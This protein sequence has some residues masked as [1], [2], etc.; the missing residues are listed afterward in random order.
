MVGFQQQRRL[1]EEQHSG[2][3]GAQ[4]GTTANGVGSTATAAAGAVG[5]QHHG[6]SSNGRANSPRARLAMLK[7]SSTKCKGVLFLFE[8]FV[9]YLLIHFPLPIIPFCQ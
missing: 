1:R 6:S 9:F 4:D 5:Q 2:E 7:R 3:E 8:Y